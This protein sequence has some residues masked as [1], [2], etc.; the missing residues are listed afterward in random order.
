[1]RNV[2]GWL[3]VRS[4]RELSIKQTPVS[5]V[6]VAD[7]HPADV[8]AALKKC[9]YNLGSVSRQHGYHPSAAY[10]ALRRHWPALEKIIADALGLEARTIWPSRYL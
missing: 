10:K 3:Q 1:M 9:G 7:W 4:R 8:E 5:K 6:A 2:P